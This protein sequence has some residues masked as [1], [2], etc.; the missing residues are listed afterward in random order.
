MRLFNY[1]GDTTDFELYNAILTLKNTNEID[2]QFLASVGLFNK[3]GIQGEF[4]TKKNFISI[5][6][7]AIRRYKARVPEDIEIIFSTGKRSVVSWQYGTK[8]SSAKYKYIIGATDNCIIS[9]DSEVGEV[10]GKNI[11]VM[12]TK[13]KVIYD[14][15]FKILCDCTIPNIL[16]SDCVCMQSIEIEDGGTVWVEGSVEVNA[17]CPIY[18]KGKVNIKG[19]PGAVLVLNNIGECQPCI[20]GR[21]N[22]GLSYKRWSLSSYRCSEIYVDGVHVVCKSIVPHFMLGEYGTCSIPKVVLTGGAVLEA[23]ECLGVRR[24]REELVSFTSDKFTEYP[25][26]YIQTETA[27]SK[28]S[29]ILEEL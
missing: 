20:G 29:K 16:L 9:V 17:S 24:M 2:P 23:E 21:T 6:D 26:Y 25:E 10:L 14:A 18:A 8:L 13:G 1:K 27:E 5:I 15:P 12:V 7:G 4:F 19:N 28:L 3:V 22:T 11:D